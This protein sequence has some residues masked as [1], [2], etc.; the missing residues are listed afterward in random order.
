MVRPCPWPLVSGTCPS[1]P[2]KSLLGG[3]DMQPECAA[4]AFPISWPQT[5]GYF[6]L[7]LRRVH[8][9][10]GPSSSLHWTTG[11]E[12]N[13]TADCQLVYSIMLS[14]KEVTLSHQ[15]V[16]YAWSKPDWAIPTSRTESQNTMLSVLKH[17]Y[18]VQGST[19]LFLWN[20]LQMARIG[21]KVN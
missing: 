9:F 1:S 4:I 12:I 15:T 21:H 8:E 16:R 3:S 20:I 17:I 6:P 7:A 2:R 19:L 18:A 14:I 11:M 5:P 10:D 13:S